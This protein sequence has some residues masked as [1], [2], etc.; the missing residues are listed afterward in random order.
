[1][2]DKE[3]ICKRCGKCCYFKLLINNKSYIT[4]IPCQYL[5][6]KTNLCRVYNN[7][8]ILNPV[9]ANIE[10]AIEKAYLPDDCAYV[11]NISNYQG[12][13]ELQDPKLLVIAEKLVRKFGGV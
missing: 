9:C 2:A 3:S 13:I 12:A 1:M 4:T 10:T 7:R 8:H 6:T 5:D 11:A